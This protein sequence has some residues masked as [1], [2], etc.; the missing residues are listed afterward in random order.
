MKVHLVYLFTGTVDPQ[1]KYILR[2]T[3]TLK[4]GSNSLHAGGGEG[5]GGVQGEVAT[6][7]INFYWVDGIYNNGEF[8]CM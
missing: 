6:L 3:V 4:A 7:K 2:D 5:G 8:G 1:G